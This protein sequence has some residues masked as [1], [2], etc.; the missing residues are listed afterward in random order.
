M[1]IRS[2]FGQGNKHHRASKG[3]KNWWGPPAGC[4]VK[5][6]RAMASNTQHT[7]QKL[8]ACAKVLEIIN[9]KPKL[10][11]TTTYTFPYYSPLK[12]NLRLPADAEKCGKKC[13]KK[14]SP[15]AHEPAHG[16]STASSKIRFDFHR[17]NVIF[18]RSILL[19]ASSS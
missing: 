17:I 13:S 18:L 19:P 7:V 4:Q 6:G 2:P 14:N 3:K 8:S 10:T 12:I 1:E 16:Q 5:D 11:F 15:Q 9:S